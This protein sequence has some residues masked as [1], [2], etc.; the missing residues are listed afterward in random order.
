MAPEVLDLIVIGWIVAMR[1]IETQQRS[2]AA[3][4]S[5]AASSSAAVAAAT[6]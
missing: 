1:D 3:A 2:N 6:G 5:S 4:A